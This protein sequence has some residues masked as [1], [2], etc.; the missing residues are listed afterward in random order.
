MS[1]NRASLCRI[2]ALMLIAL[3]IVFSLGGCRT[4]TAIETLLADGRPREV[5]RNAAVAADHPVASLAGVEMLR[6]GGNAVDAAVATSFTLSVTRPYSCGIGGGGFMLI[7]QPASAQRPAQQIAVNYREVAPKAVG[8]DY[9]VDLDDPTASKFGHNAVAVPGTVAGLLYVLERWGTLDRQTVLGPAIRAAEMG[10]IA[11]ANYVSAC[12]GFART[13]AQHS[14]LQE[15]SRYILDTL[16][17]HGQ[18]EVGDR[19]TNPDQAR[20]LRL[21]ADQGEEAFYRGE[22]AQAIASMMADNNGALAYEDMLDYSPRVDDPLIGDFQGM[23]V[24]TMPPPSSGG[25]AMQQIL[26]LLERRADAVDLDDPATA[27]SP[28]Y[29]HLLAECMKHAFADRAE[30]LADKAFVEVPVTH[31]T[32]ARYLDEL[33][34]RIDMKTT[35]DKYAYGSVTPM[36]DD[37]GTSHF[38]VIDSSGMAVAC[39]E[40]IN[41]TFG[42]GVI[43]PGFG[44]ALNN[45]MDDFTTIPGAPNAYGLQ[46]SDRNLPEPGK[47]PLSSMSPTIVVKNG[48]AVWIGGASGGPRIITGTTQVMLNSLLFDM[49][50]RHALSAARFHHQWMPEVLQFENGWDDA[51]V[52]DA[53]QQRG[54]EIGSRGGVGVVQVIHITRD[55]IR[56][57]CDPRKGG[58]PAGY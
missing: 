38:S 57:A 49:T 26:G 8:R 3:A 46:Q 34:A 16:A 42:S 40:T 17:N 33:A 52:I 12:E 18:L 43:V 39:T 13:V 7:Y 44:F 21:I 50:P 2:V 24:V 28:D 53:M 6:R 25:V 36:N 55:G 27:T 23:K 32:S 20:A 58:Q 54:H 30:F 4:K 9:Y 11:D 51:A 48:R 15:H 41:T 45:E 5:Y 1:C 56:A 22:I 37:D 19:V 31:L 35:Q 14:H 29:V 47:R 10:F